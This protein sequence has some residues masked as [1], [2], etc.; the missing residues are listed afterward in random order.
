M[1]GFFGW[2]A[3]SAMSAEV[4]AYNMMTTRLVQGISRMN[5]AIESPTVTYAYDDNR[6]STIFHERR[7]EM[8]LVTDTYLP[9]PEDLARTPEQD[10]P[11]HVV[12][13]VFGGVLSSPQAYQV[14]SIR[15]EMKEEVIRLKPTSGK[16]TM[17]LRSYNGPT[18]PYLFALLTSC[19][20]PIR[21][22]MDISD[23]KKPVW[24][25]IGSV[26]PVK[27]NQLS[28]PRK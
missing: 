18:R 25:A 13:A 9:T 12:L 26:P 20:R 28:W 21:V 24:K 8:E 5:S 17:G 1:I 10:F 3:T 2:C 6:W 16:L 19:I 27:A 15:H 4:I 14:V 23:D 7:S 11:N 22:E